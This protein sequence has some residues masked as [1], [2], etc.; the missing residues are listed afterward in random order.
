MRIKMILILSIFLMVI[1]TNCSDKG[2]IEREEA[3]Q[4]IKILYKYGFANEINTFSKTC[5]KDL[6]LDGTI[7]MD[8]W[9]HLEEQDTII[10]VLEDIDFFSLPDTLSYQP[11]D[12][13]VV[14]ISPDPGIQSLRINYISQDKTVYWYIFNSYPSEYERILRITALL[15]EILE[16]DSEYQSLPEPTGGYD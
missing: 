10:K 2:Q 13:V 11:D 14:S 15:K 4:I 8:Y 7:T 5:T 1:F 6:V 9:F 3:N 12:S 16:S